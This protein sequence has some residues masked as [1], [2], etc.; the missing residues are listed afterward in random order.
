[1]KRFFIIVSVLSFLFGIFGF[2]GS[3]SAIQDMVCILTILIGVVSLGVFFLGK[4]MED[5]REMISILNSNVCEM[6]KDENALAE[7]EK[8]R[9][10]KDLD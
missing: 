6:K 8:E 5:I 9:T 7:S 4:K 3:T 2:L 10:D 1:M